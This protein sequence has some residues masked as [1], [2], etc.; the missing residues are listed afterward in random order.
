M[1]PAPS[2]D[3]LHGLH[4]SAPRL[5][6]ASTDIV[7]ND[8]EDFHKRGTAIATTGTTEEIAHIHARLNKRDTVI[9]ELTTRVAKLGDAM[10]ENEA[11]VTDTGNKLDE[12]ERYAEMLHR[13]IDRA[14]E[15]DSR[16]AQ[17][18]RDLRSQ[19]EELS[20]D[21][22]DMAHI[23]NRDSERLR[24]TYFKASDSHQA[25]KYRTL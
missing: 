21:I 1:A 3:S 9:D 23:D 19:I 24:I 8:T 4:A 7:M 6:P 10:V 25:Y 11:M 14:D 15:E 20:D 22:L 13:S 12:I 5:N 2:K 17:I 16:L 18:Q